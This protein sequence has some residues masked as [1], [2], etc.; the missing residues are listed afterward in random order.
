MPA[1]GTYERVACA[2]VRYNP[3]PRPFC[4]FS[5]GRLLVGTDTLHRTRAC[6]E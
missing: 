5:N 1:V 2:L 6:E 4:K 3:Q